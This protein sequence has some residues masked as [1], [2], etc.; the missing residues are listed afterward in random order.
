MTKLTAENLDQYK[1]KGYIS[2]VSAL[3][4]KEAKEIRDEIEKIEKNW[5]G[6]LDGINR[7]YIH[8]ISPILNK[9]C[10]KTN[11]LDA[12]ESIIGKNIL[13]CGTTLFI[14]DPKEKGF[15]S[16]HQDAKYIGL[17]P[18]NWVTV[19]LAITDANENNGCMRMLPGSHKDN[20]IHHEQKF[21]ENNLLTRGQ[22]IENVS[23]DN[24]DPIILKAGEM[25]LHHPLIV[26]GSGLNYSDDRRIGFVI[27]S[28]IGT[29][30]KQV[31]GRN[32]VQIAR[33]KDDYNFHEKITRTR[34][35]M[36]KDD[37]KLKKQENDYLQEIFYKGS[38]K[39]GNF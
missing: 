13:I 4:S 32:S 21:D 28:Y 24:T 31:L 25:S 22:T 34:S 15:V 39:K 27:Q 36:N 38:S 16:F 1:K 17:E 29:N 12:V 23:L 2:P 37:I 9:I 18:H 8:L 33:G 20:L 5:P 7:N 19:W 6:A 10:L 35:L 30:V 14:K 11:I 26:H 3:S